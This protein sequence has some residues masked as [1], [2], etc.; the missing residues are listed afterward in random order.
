MTFGNET[1]DAT[2]SIG[3]S[4]SDGFEAL[5]QTF[6]PGSS[7][8]FSADLTTNPYSGPAPDAFSFS[9]L[10]SSDFPIPTQDP[11]GADTLLTINIDSASP[12]I[13]AY[14]TDP[15]TG[16]NA[17]DVSITMDAPVTATPVPEPGSLLLLGTGLAGLAV[18]I[19]R[20][21]K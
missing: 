5:I 18:T 7:L 1:G 8:S 17:G 6:A 13:L 2:G 14:A 16:T 4:T 19:R 20:R 15:T 3:L 9:I 21:I 11:S 12:A 10:D